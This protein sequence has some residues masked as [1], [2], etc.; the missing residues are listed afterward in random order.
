MNIPKIVL[1]TGGFDPVHRGHIEYIKAAASLGDILIIG[2]NSDAW[3]GRK[4]GKPFMNWDDRLSVV[5]NIK[6]VEE[7]VSFDDSDGSAKDAINVVRKR[8]PVSHIVFANGGDRTKTNIPEMDT[9][10]KNVS[11]VFGVGGEDKLNSSSWIIS[12]WTK[13]QNK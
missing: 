8:Y 4:K 13:E 3:L 6:Q 5:S 11:F 12:K 2:L 9:E 7:V 1:V 10:D